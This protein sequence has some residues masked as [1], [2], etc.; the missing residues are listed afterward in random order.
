MYWI[1]ILQS[2][3]EQI[4]QTLRDT[5]DSNLTKWAN[6]MQKART[7]FKFGTIQIVIRNGELVR[8]ERQTEMDD[9]S[10]GL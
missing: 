7:R 6:L 8:I 9:C 1:T 2:S 3:T 5:G 4:E 10:S